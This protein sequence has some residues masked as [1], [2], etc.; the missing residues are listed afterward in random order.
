MKWLRG[1]PFDV[2]GWDRDRRTER[3]VIAEYERLIDE[4]TG[5][6]TT[7]V[8]TTGLQTTGLQTTGLQTMGPSSALPYETL[9]QIAA[10][11]M[12]I[13]GYAS[14]K[15]TAVA[16]WREHVAELRRQDP[17]TVRAE[18]TAGRGA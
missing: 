4:T 7:G 10:S 3:A 12:S 5:V 16:A 14:I 8:Q 15:E 17:A 6:Q 9:V 11:A 1:T 13:K 18:D 2:F